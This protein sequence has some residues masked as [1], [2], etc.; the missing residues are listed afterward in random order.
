MKEWSFKFLDYHKFPDSPPFFESYWLS[1]EGDHLVNN[2]D[3][4]NLLIRL[5]QHDTQMEDPG[6]RAR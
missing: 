5:T 3:F 6:G 4:C 1:F 2:S